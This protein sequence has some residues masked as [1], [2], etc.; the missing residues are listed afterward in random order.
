MWVRIRHQ[1]MQRLGDVSFLLGE[2][3]NKRIRRP[4]LIFPAPLRVRVVD[5]V[6]ELLDGAAPEPTFSSTGEG[7]R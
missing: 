4:R 1:P 2:L 5:A 7:A 3:R 6:R